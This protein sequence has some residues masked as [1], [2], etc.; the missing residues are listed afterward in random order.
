MVSYSVIKRNEVRIHATTW[1]NLGN[2]M[3][4]ERKPD[5]KCHASYDS[6]YLGGPEQA[7]PQRQSLEV[8]K[9]EKGMEITERIRRFFVG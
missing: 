9:R 1:T 4:N 8:D 5:R 2:T 7:N 3:P 6:A